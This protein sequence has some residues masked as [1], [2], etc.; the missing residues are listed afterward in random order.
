MKKLVA[1]CML[2]SL[3]LSGVAGVS[4][5]EPFRS[6]ESKA[7][8]QDQAEKPS[9]KQKLVWAFFDF[10]VEMEVYQNSLNE[11]LEKKGL[12]YEIEFASV[13]A[14]YG[15]YKT[16]T[17]SCVEEVEKGDYDIITCPDIINCYDLY[18]MLADKGILLPMTELLEKKEA[19][20]KLKEAYPSVIWESMNYQ[21]E[22]YGILTPDTCTNYYA[23]FHEAY[24][25]KYGIDV[26]QVTFASLEKH[27]RAARAGENRERN[28]NFVVS[29]LLPYCLES[30][31]FSPCGLISIDTDGEDATAESI[32]C[33][34]EFLTYTKTLGEWAKDGIFPSI[35]QDWEKEFQKGN[36]LVTGTYA[37]SPEAA[38][39]YCRSTYN[40]PA[41][42]KLQVVELPEFG[43]SFYR[44]GGKTGIK[45]SSSH[46]EEAFEVLAAIYSD[47]ELSNALVY[48]KEGV[49]Y[50]MEEGKAV[51]LD[52]YQG[53][54]F[55]M[56]QYLG[57]PFL[58]IPGVWDSVSKKEELSERFQTIEIAVRVKV[59]FDLE[60]ID[61]EIAQ[62]NTLFLD[63]YSEFFIEKKDMEKALEIIRKGADEI[64]IEKVLSELNRQ[65]KRDR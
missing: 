53:A 48:G 26:S 1:V 44:A 36:F 61:A 59:P 47:E 56:R 30:L 43:K 45:K 60:G 62:L 57:N 17:S 22:I 7:I 31:E 40:I 27:L 21:G 8:G 2:F 35:Y 33:K 6:S 16:Y 46:S 49:S 41:E 19:G 51:R 54:E 39:S 28:K 55:H 23:V 10:P 9:E 37:Y 3:I 4:P 24:A 14:S 65:L 13:P 29:D 38:E 34:E 42:T 50:R 58:T 52:E 5:K 32:L 15:D 64:G 18:T 11:E 25:D 12:P 63:T 20:K